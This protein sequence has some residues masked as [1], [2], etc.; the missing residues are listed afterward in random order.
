MCGRHLPALL[1]LRV[2]RH[3][4]HP[5]L[6]CLVLRVS[7]ELGVCGRVDNVTGA[8]IVLVIELLGVSVVGGGYG[9]GVAL[10]TLALLIMEKLVA[11]VEVVRRLGLRRARGN[12]ARA[13][14]YIHWRKARGVKRLA[15]TL[16]NLATA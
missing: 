2:E 15:T 1:L 16:I 6:L 9:G 8:I 7:Y 12:R 11:T 10:A 4:G 5:L 14:L 13:P 3:M